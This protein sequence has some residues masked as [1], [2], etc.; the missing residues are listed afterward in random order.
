MRLYYTIEEL[1]NKGLTRKFLESEFTTSIFLTPID[2]QPK[3][4]IETLVVPKLEYEKV[5]VNDGI[6]D[7]IFFVLKK[8]YNCLDM[9]EDI[10]TLIELE[11]A[12]NKGITSQ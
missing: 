1:V 7:K 10:K 4:C 9:L 11:T 2:I 8:A 12:K 6:Q 3:I 5:I